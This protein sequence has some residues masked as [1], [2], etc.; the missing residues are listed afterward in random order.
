[1]LQYKNAASELFVRFLILGRVRAGVIAILPGRYGRV[2]FLAMRSGC[3]RARLN[4]RYLG[5]WICWEGSF[6][7]RARGSSHALGVRV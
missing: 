6:A 5:G 7:F 4:T 1:M 3:G 2:T